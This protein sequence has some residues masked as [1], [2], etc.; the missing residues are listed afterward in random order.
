MRK[1][2]RSKSGW[3]PPFER[4]GSRKAVSVICRLEST[5]SPTFLHYDRMKRIHQYHTG[6]VQCALTFLARI[7]CENACVLA[8][9]GNKG[10]PRPRPVLTISHC[11]FSQQSCRGIYRG[12]TLFGGV[13]STSQKQPNWAFPA[14]QTMEAS[15]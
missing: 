7:K 3:I 10:L 6:R 2:A 9:V 11:A 5:N 4:G 12:A 8:R 1:R 15:K 14:S 13:T